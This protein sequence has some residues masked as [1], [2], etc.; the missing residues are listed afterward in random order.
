M[1]F[2]TISACNSYSVPSNLR[3]HI[4]IVLPT[5]NFDTRMGSRNN[6]Q[7][8]ARRADGKKAAINKHIVIPGKK[9][10]GSVSPDS[11]DNCDKQITPACLRALYNF[12]YHPVATH[13]NSYG[14]GESGFYTL[15]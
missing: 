12:N 10:F 14:I 13:Q 15:S 6:P 1:P 7:S 5:V 9:A 3:E 4:D 2:Y 11:L 8:L